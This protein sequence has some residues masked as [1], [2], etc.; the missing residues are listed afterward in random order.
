MVHSYVS[1]SAGGKLKQIVVKR[2]LAVAAIGCG[3]A[4]GMFMH[5]WIAGI[6]AACIAYAAMI[7]AYGHC[8]GDYTD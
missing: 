1:N 8:T 3:I 7:G 6:I 5:N 4:V 2:S